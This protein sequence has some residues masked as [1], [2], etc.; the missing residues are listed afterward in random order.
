MLDYLHK[1]ARIMRPGYYLFIG[2]GVF[3]ALTAILVTLRSSGPRGDQWLIPSLLLMVWGT[4]A[5][6]FV[7]SF[8]T[9]PERAPPALPWRHRLLRR[10]QRTGYG[11]LGLGFI[12]ASTAALLLSLRLLGVWLRDY[13]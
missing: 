3:G 10:L 7:R 8:Q 4:W 6:V 12:A 1:L 13:G 5:Y 2:L 9:V 11:L